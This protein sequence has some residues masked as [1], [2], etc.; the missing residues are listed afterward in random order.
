MLLVLPVVWILLTV[1]LIVLLSVSACWL[2]ASC[3]PVDCVCPTLKVNLMN[4]KKKGKKQ[5]APVSRRRH[6]R[7]VCIGCASVCAYISYA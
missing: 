2:P 4:M 1:L 5:P 6:V 7:E 3:C